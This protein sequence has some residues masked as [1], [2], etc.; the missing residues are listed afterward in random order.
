MNV[1]DSESVS[2]GGN[3]ILARNYG[4]KKAGRGF[5]GCLLTDVDGETMLKK[6]FVS[7]RRNLRVI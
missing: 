3:T 2:N 1:L 4:P 5:C 6:V 7:L